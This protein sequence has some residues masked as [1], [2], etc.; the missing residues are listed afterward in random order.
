M[1]I[2]LD[3]RG[4]GQIEVKTEIMTRC[5]DCDATKLLPDGT[6][7]KRCNK[8]GEI[9]TGKFNVE[10]QLCKTCWGSG[11]VSEQS[12]TIWFLIR[13]V[14]TTLII[15]GGG[16][17][18]IWASWSFLGILWLTALLTIIVF[19]LWGG[20]VYYFVS[21]MPSLGEIS[22]TNWFLIRA[23]PTT[24][25]ALPI[26]GAIIWSSWVYLNNA[27]VTAIITLTAFAIWGVLMY[28]FISHLPE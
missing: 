18:L 8:W 4:T 26:G 12:L 20:L 5:P 16:I 10:K 3:C 9:G 17:P 19:G 7:C 23:V 22:A 15:L 2:C 6:T 28:Y 13:V 24:I 25:A 11:R 1:P 27:P 21:Q 14:P